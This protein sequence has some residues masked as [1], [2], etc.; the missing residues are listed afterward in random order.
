MYIYLYKQGA[1]Y[2][3]QR[4]GVVEKVYL[5]MDESNSGNGHSKD[6]ARKGPEIYVACISTYL[7][8]FRRNGHTLKGKRNRSIPNWNL[9]MDNGRDFRY[10]VVP[11]EMFELY[12]QMYH[13]EKHIVR[14]LIDAFATLILSC[15]NIVN[16]DNLEILIDGKQPARIMGGIAN[17]LTSHE[18]N[19]RSLSC[20][21]KADIRFPL[22]NHA[23]NIASYLRGHY[24]ADPSLAD[25]KKLLTPKQCAAVHIDKRVPMIHSF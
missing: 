3:S 15:N 25:D 16:P 7:S 21:A 9:F 14:A 2:L 5:G 22:V 11:A 1:S 17:V 24:L 4:G 20:E 10:V 12:K 23:D 8:D 18:I 6:S 13:N 19:P